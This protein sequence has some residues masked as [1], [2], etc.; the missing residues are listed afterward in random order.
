MRTNFTAWKKRL[1]QPHNIVALC[2]V[3]VL[4]VLL[5]P[6]TGIYKSAVRSL[7][8][9]AHAAGIYYLNYSDADLAMQMGAYYFSGKSYD[10]DLAAKSYERAVALRPTILQAHYQLA[11]IYFVQGNLAAARDAINAELAINP[12]NKRSL[13]IRGLIDIAQNDLPAAECDFSTFVAWAP[14]EW[15]GYNDLA[16]TLAKE[17]KYPESEA[18]I[19]KALSNVPNAQ[20]NPWLFNS[21]GLAQLNQLQYVAAEAS[22]T[23]A[24]ALASTLTD[25]QWIR[26]YSANDPAGAQQSLET[27]QQS[28]RKNLSTAKADG[29]MGE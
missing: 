27:F 2:I 23:K 17:Q 4:A 10:L 19:K 14:T 18:T 26:A 20:S 7:W 29:T 8:N 13:Y 3:L 6:G 24:L 25:A 28:I 1:L 22:F 16:Y 21:L 5:L 12:P 15:G 11:R 9:H